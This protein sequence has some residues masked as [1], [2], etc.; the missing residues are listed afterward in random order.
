MTMPPNEVKDEEFPG[1]E[2][3]D[4]DSGI[5]IHEDALKRRYVRRRLHLATAALLWE[6]LWPALWPA[7]LIGGAFLALALFDLLPALPPAF[8]AGVLIAFA[9][10][11]F[12]ALYR[13]RS[14][15]GW[16]GRR[17]AERR[18]ERETGLAHRPLTVLDDRPAEAPLS[19][20]QTELWRAHRQR[21]ALALS[22]LK[23]GLPEAGL[24][25]RDPFG[26]RII[27]VLALVLA[28][29]DARQDA[30]RRILRAV[31][32]HF[33][34]STAPAVALDVWVT[35][36][37]Y[38]GLPTLVLAR[39]GQ[40]A[41]NG[42]PSVLDKDGANKDGLPGANK[43]ANSAKLTVPAGSVLVAQVHGGRGTPKLRTE[44]NAVTLSLLGADS[45][46]GTAILNSPIH[47]VVEQG[48]TVLGSW[49][50]NVIPDA[51]PKI[52]FKE[53]PT[54]SE[55]GALRLSYRVEDDY[56]VT[57]AKG[58]ISRAQSVPET[59][60]GG[61]GP[62][63]V[64]LPLPGGAVKQA[65]NVSYHDLTAH[66]WAG[67]EVRMH[68]EAKD[69][70]GQT[71]MSESV[72]FVLPER[73]FHNEAA[74]EIVAERKRLTIDPDARRE[75]AM[76]IAGLA[77]EPARFN[78]DVVVFMALG[79]AARRL[80]LDREPSAVASVQSLL[81]DTAL[82]LEDNGASL[83]QRDIRDIEKALRDALAKGA[84]GKE[85]KDLM[86]KLQQAL[87]RYLD[88]LSRG[89][90]PNEGEN[91]PSGA[92]NPSSQ[93]FSPDDLRNMLDKARQLAQ[94]G[95]RQAAQE[96]LSKL[97]DI[98]EN[99]RT[100]QPRES[101]SQQQGR[102]AMRNLQDM[103]N[104]QSG[105]LDRSFNNAQPDNTPQNEG[106]PQSR[107]GGQ[108][109]QSRPGQQ[110]RSGP[111]KSGDDAQAQE[112]LRR[113]LGDS[114]LKLGDMLGQIPQPLGRAERAMRDAVEALKKGSPQEALGPQ[115]KA[116]DQLQQAMQEI[117]QQMAK[118]SQQGDQ[119]GN[120]PGPRQ[121]QGKDPLGRPLPEQGGQGAN[122]EKVRIPDEMEM[123]RA[124]E[125]LDELRKRA[126]E[127]QRP[128]S[129]R[130]YI[131]RLLP[132]Y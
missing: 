6:T 34:I 62:I 102:E 85:I 111:G 80:M 86:D 36:L 97:Q 88:M 3:G 79:S 21:M 51:P 110:G 107:K 48:G 35:P 31:T 45:Y 101:P 16:P 117:R 74:K 96:M 26:L 50:L 92:Q 129:E 19:S 29:A 9:I 69:G 24:A 65:E 130:D 76:A 5:P 47:A 68:L 71:G 13:A 4:D 22:R 93:T 123:R 118:Q 55:H 25:K 15:I 14:E 103:I 1:K 105:L 77:N 78:N 100:A 58:V 7:V 126:G 54:R 125:I 89:A 132:D 23:V 39:S 99:L 42:G 82:R 17:A 119:N 40:P 122:T 49:D 115:A 59:I 2:F 61:N 33:P 12:A 98:L 60:A 64:S 104:R 121:G 94:T 120:Q 37:A 27:L 70:A 131:E 66:P 18:I 90:E 112:E 106:P 53:P 116:L 30:G 113:Q 84:E 114:M 20:A 109:G 28:V 127:Q 10:T 73:E 57:E 124:R 75:V 128:R 38:T 32:P 41:E 46:Q 81:W 56:G 67:T 108:P 95:D 52:A 63:E 72:T 91:P 44:G 43:P 87:N 11:F 8:H 83:A